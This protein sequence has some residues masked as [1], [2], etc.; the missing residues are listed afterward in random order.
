MKQPYQMTAMIFEFT[1]MLFGSLKSPGTDGSFYQPLK[2]NPEQNRDRL[3]FGLNFIA[4]LD[5]S[6]TGKG[7]T[8]FAMKRRNLK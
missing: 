4:E 7:W 1:N 3:N 8:L 5:V 2:G 6:S